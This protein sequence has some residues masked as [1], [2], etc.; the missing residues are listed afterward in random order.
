[1][2]SAAGDGWGVARFP[3]RIEEA[4][5][6]ALRLSRPW[7]LP[8]LHS[9]FSADLFTRAAGRSD[10]PFGS[11]L[12]FWM[13]L[14]GSFDVVYLAECQETGTRR[15]VGFVGLYDL[16]PGRSVRLSMAIFDPAERR[17]GYGERSMET[18]CLYLR[19]RAIVKAVFAEV[20]R[21]NAESLA[22]LSAVKFEMCWQRKGTLI[23]QRHRNTVTSTGPARSSS[24]QVRCARATR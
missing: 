9:L 21:D 13:W 5:G 14:R 8:A 4:P 2:Q 11:V 10:R 20:S 16:R 1:M 17:R 19:R 23:L 18:L 7:D 15:V 3:R 22:F 12:S 6:F 24:P